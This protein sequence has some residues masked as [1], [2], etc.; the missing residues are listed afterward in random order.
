MGSTG[1]IVNVAG[2]GCEFCPIGTAR[3]VNG[4]SSTGC[5]AATS[6]CPSNWQY[7]QYGKCQNCIAGKN[8]NALKTGCEFCPP[9]SIRGDTS[10]RPL[11][12]CA[13]FCSKWQQ[14]LYG[15]CNDCT[16][17]KVGGY[18]NVGCQ[19]CVDGTVRGADG[20]AK[21][22]CVAAA[23][24]CLPSQYGF[25][26]KCQTCTFPQVPKDDRTGCMN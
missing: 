19:Y 18:G 4:T 1:K 2:T 8:S 7:A 9:G 16:N 11:A 15:K 17:G 24:V 14:A 25:C 26:G 20:T 13:F 22:G 5:Q 3:G 23:D 12:S 10:G 6:L 21:S